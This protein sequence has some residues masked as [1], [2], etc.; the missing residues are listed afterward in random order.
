MNSRALKYFKILA[1]QEGTD[2]S[3]RNEGEGINR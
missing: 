1:Q 3:V 2:C